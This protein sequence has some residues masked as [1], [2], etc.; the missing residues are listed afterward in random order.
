LTSVAPNSISQAKPAETA[1]ASSDIIDQPPRPRVLRRILQAA[2]GLLI[3]W[4]IVCAGLMLVVH[5]YG[6]QT[7]TQTAD[8]IIVLGSGVRRDGRPGDA[9]YRRS[10]HAAELYTEGYAPNVICTG[11]QTIGY[12][13]SEADACRQVLE[14]NGVPTAAILLDDHSRS[15]EENAINS[16]AIMDAQ[17][18]QDAVL[19]SDSFH[20]LRAEWIFELQGLTVYPNPVQS[21]RIRRWWYVQ[22]VGREVLALQWQVFKEALNLPVTYVPI[23]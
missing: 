13:R 14:E 2:I 23:G 18:W 12:P 15:T 21:T 17:S 5:Q 6:Q 7:S 20:M 10:L 22:F 11:G 16:Q 3:V 1:S 8:V 4:I 9:L 19:V